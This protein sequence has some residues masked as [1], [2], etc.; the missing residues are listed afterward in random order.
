M[1]GIIALNAIISR[2]TLALFEDS[3]WVT[4]SYIGLKCTHARLL[5]VIPYWWLAYIGYSSS[6]PVAIAGTRST[7]T[8][9]NFYDMDKILDVLTLKRA[10]LHMGMDLHLAIQTCISFQSSMMHACF[11][12]TNECYLHGQECIQFLTI[13]QSHCVYIHCFSTCLCYSI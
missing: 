2:I 8:T 10:V 11:K 3:G 13:W 12:S 6:T 1:T 5:L 9:L 7:T 4:I